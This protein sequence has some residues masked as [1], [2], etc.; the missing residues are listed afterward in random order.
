MIKYVSLETT[1]FALLNI[2]VRHYHH[3]HKSLT[4]FFEH[5]EDE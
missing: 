4:N 5:V 2:P 3:Q 1:M